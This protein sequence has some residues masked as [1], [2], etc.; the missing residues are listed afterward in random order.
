MAAVIVAFVSQKGGVG[1]STLA[2]ALAAYL[3]KEDMNVRIADLDSQQITSTKW[4]ARRRENGLDTPNVDARPYPDVATALDDLGDLDVMIVDAYA[5]SSE[6]TLRVAEA[7]DVVVQPTNGGDD[8]T[9]PAVLVFYDL[10]KA[11]IEPERMLIA[12][13]RI[14]TDAEE[15]EGRAYFEAADIP[16]KVLDGAL[17][18]K[19]SYG[20]ALSD[21]RTVLETDYDSLNMAAEKL[22]KALVAEIVAVRAKKSKPSGTKKAG[23]RVA[24]GVAA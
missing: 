11:G 15:R 12:L 13:A 17:Y 19:R 20:R 16:I 1:K 22:L 4:L 21:G 9:E 2:R 6:G 24:T 5:R 3:A 18:Q 7:A 23:R 10:Y 8:D 14:T